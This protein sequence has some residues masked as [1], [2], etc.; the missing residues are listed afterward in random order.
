MYSVWAIWFLKIA[1][2]NTQSIRHESICEKRTISLNKL[3]LSGVCMSQG[4]IG[5]MSKTKL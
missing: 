2:I 5:C 1:A 3:A 4:E